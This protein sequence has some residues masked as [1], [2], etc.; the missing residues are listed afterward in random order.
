M[1]GKKTILLRMI[2]WEDDFDELSARVLFGR[3]ELTL[4]WGLGEPMPAGLVD[5]I[6]K[7]LGQD[8]TRAASASVDRTNSGVLRVVNRVLAVA[9]E[10]EKEDK[11]KYDAAYAKYV[12]DA[13]E[14]SEAR[15]FE[16]LAALAK[17]TEGATAS[18]PDELNTVEALIEASREH[19]DHVHAQLRSLVQ[20]FGGY[21]EGEGMCARVHERAHTHAHGTEPA[22]P[23][24][25]K[26]A[27]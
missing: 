10:Q 21:Y 25:L 7:A 22:L 11:D 20:A 3:N 9:E 19:N 17:K 14:G 2:A 15:L 18:Q 26:P 16:M 5:D 12:S 24:Q 1:Q 13:P 23:P 27:R 8:A 4:S 6:M